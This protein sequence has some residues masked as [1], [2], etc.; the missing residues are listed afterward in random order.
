MPGAHK[1]QS[2]DLG[3]G[4]TYLLTWTTYGSWLPGDARGY[5]SF[6][7]GTEHE[8]VI[9]NVPGEPYD[10]DHSDL[11]EH[12]ST[13]QRGPTVLL[14]VTH[15]RVCVE[16]FRE[17]A[18]SHGLCIGAGAVMTNHVHLVVQPESREGAQLLNLFKGVS[19]RQLTQQFGHPIGAKWWTRHGSRRALP[20]D[21]AVGAAVEYVWNQP[22]RLMVFAYD[23]NDPLVNE[24]AHNEGA[25]NEGARNEEPQTLRAQSERV[26]AAVEVPGEHRDCRANEHRIR[27][28][29]AASE[30]CRSS[31][32]GAAEHLCRVVHETQVFPSRPVH[33]AGN[34]G[35]ISNGVR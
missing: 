7:P 21:R 1:R 32:S 22:S 16:S 2:T 9:H 18:R 24:G 10:F 25:H 29:D 27:R 34:D 20:D 33:E 30:Q 15:A 13:L 31:V 14:G 11:R 8:Y 19:S 17:T 4:G 26:R 12:A 5:V 3:R 23:P 35:N 6:T 28:L